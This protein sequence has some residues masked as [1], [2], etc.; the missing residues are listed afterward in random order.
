MLITF[1][2]TSL[3]ITSVL[4]TFSLVPFWVTLHCRD[5]VFLFSTVHW[6]TPPSATSVLLVDGPTTTPYVSGVTPISHV[7]GATPTSHVTGAP[8]HPLHTTS[9]PP[10]AHILS[11][12]TARDAAESAAKQAGRRL[13][14]N[15]TE[16]AHTGAGVRYCCEV[17][18]LHSCGR[19]F[20][21]RS[22]FHSSR[23]MAEEEACQDLL[24]SSELPMYNLTADAAI[25]SH[26]RGQPLIEPN[27]VNAREGG[28]IGPPHMGDAAQQIVSVM[29]RSATTSPSYYQEHPQCDT[30]S[31]HHSQSY[32]SPSAVTNFQGPP[33]VGNT[34]PFVYQGYPQGGTLPTNYQGYPQ[35]GTGNC[36]GYP[37]A[38]NT[39]PTDYQGYPQV[40]TGNYQS[41]VADHFEPLSATTHL[42]HSNISPG[43]TPKMQLKEYCDRKQWPNPQYST[44]HFGNTFQSKVLVQ[45]LGSVTGSRL[46]NKKKAEHDAAAKAISQLPVS[47]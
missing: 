41:V 36:Q 9:Q 34:S 21:G 33:P 10:S 12:L 26:Q 31:S 27:T 17:D 19:L 14:K 29:A 42:P 20:K 28:H 18:F 13:N 30:V 23:D 46:A 4:S 32:G 43:K 1:P 24:R 11:H 3:P 37:Q 39:L 16:E 25:G 40:G 45:G 15:F 44:Q 35:V 5:Y 38:G 47:D 22:S 8:P 6:T 2:L 7:S